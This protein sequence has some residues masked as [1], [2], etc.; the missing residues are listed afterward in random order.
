MFAPKQS[1]PKTSPKKHQLG[2]TVSRYLDVRATHTLDLFGDLQD[3]RVPAE[4]GSFKRF[5]DFIWKIS[6]VILVGD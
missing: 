4:V 2:V 1:F 6:D 5:R 3:A